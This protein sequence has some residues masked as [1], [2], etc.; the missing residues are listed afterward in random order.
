MESSHRWRT[1]LGQ[2][3]KYVL[4]LFGEEVEYMGPDAAGRVAVKLGACGSS[5]L[6]LSMFLVK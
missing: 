4:H 1:V 2:E 3:H 6:T 5:L